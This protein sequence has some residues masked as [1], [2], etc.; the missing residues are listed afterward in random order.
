VQ[1]FGT[2]LHLDLG[3]LRLRLSFSLDDCADA[4]HTR[5]EDL[6]RLELLK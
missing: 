2:S 6:P 4:A 5:V 3:N 1:L